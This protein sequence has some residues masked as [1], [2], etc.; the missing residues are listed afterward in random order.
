[1]KKLI[2]FLSKGLLA[3]TL[4]FSSLG[5]KQYYRVSKVNSVSARDI[6][7]YI[8]NNKF[9]V[10]HQNNSA[11]RLFN[12][13]LSEN[14]LYGSLINLNANNLKY[15]TT[16]SE[17]KNRYRK[18]INIDESEVLNEVHL[19]LSG[20]LIEN[21]E[22]ASLVKIPLSEIVFADIYHKDK[23]ATLISWGGTALLGTIGGF[24]L[25][26][27]AGKALKDWMIKTSGR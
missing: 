9:I 4:I 10:I 11:R 7:S 22:K 2:C 1:M 20:P 25:I 27:L 15:K 21:F 18:T 19:F 16:K 13:D 26:D 24:V 5:C 17:G 6:A 23:K 12:P 8:A 3:V 14:I